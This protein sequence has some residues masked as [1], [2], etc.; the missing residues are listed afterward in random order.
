V[1]C[2]CNCILTLSGSDSCLGSK[3]KLAEVGVNEM[4]GR[5][6]KFIA[7]DGRSSRSRSGAGR[8]EETDYFMLGF[9]VGRSTGASECNRRR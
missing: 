5:T 3:G 6:L 9:I 7:M 1:D 4:V 8:N 2:D